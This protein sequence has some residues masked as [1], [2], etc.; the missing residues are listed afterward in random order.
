MK[1]LILAGG[2]GTRLWPLSSSHKPKQFQ[3]LFGEKTMLQATVE[4]V[5]PLVP[6]K[7]IYIGTS[8]LYEKEVKKQLPKIPTKNIILEPD[9]RGEVAAFLLFF[10]FLKEEDFS[11]PI[12]ILSSDHLIKDEEKLR[13]SLIA[14]QK[15]IKK[16]SDR[17][18]L[19]S[20]KPTSPDIGLGYIQ[21][22]EK[23]EKVEGFDIFKI[24]DFKEK[25]NIN[26]AKEYLKLG[27]Y[28]WNV[29]I[30]IFTPALLIELVKKFVP[31]SYQRY[32]KI[33]KAFSAKG[34]QKAVE[35]EF[36]EMDNVT[37]SYSILE[38]YQENTVLP[39]SMGWS[40][41][42]SWAV[43]KDCLTDPSSKNYIRGNCMNIDSENIFVYGS[44]DKL[45]ATIGVKDLVIVT[46]GDT[47]LVC[48]LKRS[49]EVKKIV[50]KLNKDKKSKYL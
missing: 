32:L 37:F 15:F 40:D 49:Q 12:I 3:K 34:F 46:T 36:P 16:N 43:L 26:K 41:I 50:E 38:N 27:D 20:E 11:E 35:K 4:R 23:I 42:G 30:Y 6:I 39:I 33:R 47:I 24:K 18:L 48:D 25:P 29:G 8:Q 28:F 19:L 2:K 17:I 10:C 9:F 7:D 45:I 31:D 44:N 1:I 21:R 22:S 5:L 13:E 14:G